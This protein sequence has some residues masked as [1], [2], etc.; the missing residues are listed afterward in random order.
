MGRPR[1][2]TDEAI[3]QTARD[4]FLELGPGA[5]TAVIA[6]RMGISQASVFKR[7]GTKEAL[8]IAALH[9]SPGRWQER[10]EAG[11]DERPIRSQIHELALEMSAFMEELIPRVTMLRAAGIDV[12]Q[13]MRSSHRRPPPVKNF[14]LFVAWFEAAIGQGRVRRGNAEIYAIT[15]LGSINATAF[16]EHLAGEPLVASDREHFV[17]DFVEMFWRSLD[18]DGAPT[19]Q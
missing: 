8:L 12:E 11:P 19:G 17:E 7:F 4:V 1:K 6:E 3:L 5:S 16:F 15:L 13:L 10:L 2:I 14:Q 18:P 9:P